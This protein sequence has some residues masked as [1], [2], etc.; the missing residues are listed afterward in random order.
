MYYF[1][2]SLLMIYNKIIYLLIYLLIY[3]FAYL[4]IY[5]STYLLI[6]FRPLGIGKCTCSSTPSNSRTLTAPNVFNRINTA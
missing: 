2:N 3:L 1:I 5:L 6:Y 4:S